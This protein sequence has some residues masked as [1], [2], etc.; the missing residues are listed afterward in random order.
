M[1]QIIYRVVEVWEEE[2][3]TERGIWFQAPFAKAIKDDYPEIEKVGRFNS[4][5]LFGAGSNEFRRA[6]QLENFHEE[7]F[8]YADQEFLDLMAIPF[9][10][11]NPARAL[12][13]AQYYCHHK[14]KSG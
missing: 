10:Y 2:G 12:D 11:G 8:V 5:E 9:V 13:D 3:K 4:S 1:R 14:T 7:G 6:D